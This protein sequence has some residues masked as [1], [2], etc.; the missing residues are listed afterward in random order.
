MR[1][2]IHNP[3]LAAGGSQPSSLENSK[4]VARSTR[5]SNGSAEKGQVRGPRGIQWGTWLI[6]F[7]CFPIFSPLFLFCSGPCPYKTFQVADDCNAV[8]S[9]HSPRSRWRTGNPTWSTLNAKRRP[10]AKVNCYGVLAKTKHE[11]CGEFFHFKF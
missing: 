5:H 7:F 6:L 8:R 3:I 2:Y 10:R 1:V 9:M 11:T 4:Q